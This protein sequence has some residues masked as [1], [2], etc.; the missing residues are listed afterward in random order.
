MHRNMGPLG[1]LE[2]IG[3]FPTV[4]RMDQRY[5]DIADGPPKAREL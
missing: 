5:L 1:D 4:H 2:D 3:C